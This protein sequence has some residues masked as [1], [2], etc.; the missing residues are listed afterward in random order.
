VG[1]P[2]YSAPEQIQGRPV[3]GRA[4]QYALACV[5]YLLLTGEVPFERDQGLAVLLAHLSEPPPSLSAR[6][7]GLPAAADEVLARGMAKAPE[8]RYRSCR[9]FADALRAALGLAP[10]SAPGTA[11]PADHPHTQFLS[12]PPELPGPA[13]A[14]PA[15]DAVPPVT[16]TTPSPV[17]SA[18][19]PT[20]ARPD[21]SPTGPS[22][23]GEQRA[24]PPRRD[25]HRRAVTGGPAPGEETPRAPRP[26]RA[27]SRRSMISAAAIGIAII[28]LIIAITTLSAAPRS[29]AGPRSSSTPNGPAASNLFASVNLNGMPAYGHGVTGVT[30]IGT[31][32]YEVTFADDVQQCAYV[33]TTIN[34]S[35]QAL[36]V[37]TAG[38][39][40]GP[41]GVYVETKNQ[42]GGLTDGPFNLVVDCGRPGWFY[43]VVGYSDNLVRSTPGLILTNLGIGRYD[44]TF[45]ADI[46]RCAYLATVGDPGNAL[47]YNP[48]GVYTASG[49]D[50]ST[51]Y[52]ET[53]NPGGGLSGG[54]P[55]HLA[56]IC[57]TAA[58]VKVAV[59]AAN[60]RIS[61]GSGHVSSSSQASGQ[62]TLTTSRPLSGCATVAT[63]GSTGNTV[64]Y[65]PATV[66]IV[67]G[68]ARQAV[69]IQVRG[70]L[71][72][73]GK[74]ASESFHA[75]LVC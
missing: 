5:A 4:D 24:A 52:I 46:S 35:S 33:A 41:H 64:P 29:S 60:G 26:G 17:Y 25:D 50:P 12:P 53:K 36:Q 27:I 18:A 2:D 73:G 19:G 65:D 63:R 45:P 44:V 75:A 59:V 37:F 56:V 69:G 51:V 57:P 55:F 68:A 67:P 10:Y 34:T 58:S 72:F 47:V 7:P 43:A 22:G 30:H 31:G 74:L 16:E 39:H 62:Y 20:G 1:T 40:L 15:A 70:L 66:Q 49:G 8:E 21:A 6:R 61:R 23:D 32:Q 71:F 14:S 9:D 3:D 38:G 11:S 42:D 48:G 54:I 28:G 13:A